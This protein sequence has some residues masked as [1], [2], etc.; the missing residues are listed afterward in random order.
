MANTFEKLKGSFH[1][2]RAVT[3]E[4]SPFT[5][6]GEPDKF[7][8]KTM[9]RPDQA[10]LMKIMDLQSKG[11]KNKLSKDEDGYYTNFSRPTEVKGRAG[12]MKLDP[13]KVYGADGTTPIDADTVG[14]GSE[15]ELTVELYEH[16]TPNGGKA[17]AARFYAATITKLVE[18]EQREGNAAEAYD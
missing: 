1:Y 10:S 4:K 15:G 8:W 14:N 11:V 2:M 16:K 13:P 18:R 6:Q 7:A 12:L 9:F 5:K 3:A 17:H